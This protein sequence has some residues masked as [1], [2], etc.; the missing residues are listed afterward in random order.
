MVYH[1]SLLGRQV[2]ITVHLIIVERADAGRPKPKRLRSEIQALADGA[3]FEMHI[4]IT[5]V[6][7]GA[8]GT[9]EIADH[10]E[11]HAC[12]TGEILPEAQARGRDALV[13]TLDLLQLGALRPEPVDAGL[14]PIDA[15]S[16]QIELDETRA[17]KISKQWLGCSRRGWP[18]AA[19]TTSIAFHP[20][21]RAPNAAFG[22][23]R[24]RLRVDEAGGGSLISP[25][26]VGAG[27][28]EEMPLLPLLLSF[29]AP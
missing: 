4:A 14:Q 5:T 9:I 11:R 7:I 10:R 24:Q 25:E 26:P 8:G 3:G 29:V 19:P 22:R 20:G 23:P 15:M 2:E 17:G 1:L 13:A 21:S 28:A 6:S 27:S 18:R 16:I 12:V